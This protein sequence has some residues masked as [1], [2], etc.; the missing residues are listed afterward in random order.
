MATT[1]DSCSEQTNECIIRLFFE[2]RNNHLNNIMDSRL[3]NLVGLGI[4]SF[5]PWFHTSAFGYDVLLV[6]YIANIKPYKN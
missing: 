4:H 5:L 6:Y 3:N 2:F 1:H